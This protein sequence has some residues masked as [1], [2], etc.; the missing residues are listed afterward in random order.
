MDHTYT[1][2]VFY[3]IIYP[4]PNKVKY[5]IE[6]NTLKQHILRVNIIIV[7]GYFGFVRCFSL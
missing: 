7:C 3:I 5:V 4:K 2:P 1:Y 6:S